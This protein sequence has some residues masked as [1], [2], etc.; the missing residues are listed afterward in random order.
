MQDAA[1]YGWAGQILDINLSNGQIVKKPLTPEFARKWIGGEGFGAKILWDEVGPEVEDGLDPRNVL[2]YAAGPLNSTLAPNSGRLE[3]VTKSPLTGIFGDTNSGGYFAPEM[4]QAGYDVI[5]IRGKAEKPVYL[6]IDDDKVQIRDAG[7]LWGRDV[8]ETTARLQY[9]LGDRDVQVSCIGP[10]GENLVRFAIL[11]NNLTRAPGWTGC[12]A[13]AGSKN[14]KA[15]TIRGTRGVRIAHPQEFEEACREL[16]RKVRDNRMFETRRKIG[17]MYLFRMMHA[18]GHSALNNYNITQSSRKYLEKI[19][20]D[21]WARDYVV[22]QTSCHACEIHCGHFAEVREGPYKGLAADGFEY[23]SFGAFLS[24]YGSDNLSFAMAATKY[25]NDNGMDAT[26]PGLILAWLTDCFKRGIITLDDT[27]GLTLDWGDEKVALEILRKI[28]HR[29]GFGD[30]LAEGL[31][32]ASRKIGRGSGYY[33]QV[34]KG[35]PSFEFNVRVMYGCA[36]ASATSTRGGDHLK[37]WPY[38]ELAHAGGAPSQ[39]RWGNPHAGDNTSHEGKSEMTAYGQRV[40]TLI[41]SLGT[42]KFLSRLGLEGLDEKDYTRLLSLATGVDFTVE[43]VMGAADRIYNL[44]Q[45]YNIRLG[46]GRKDDTVPE[47]YVSEPCDSG[48]YEGKIVIKRENFEKMLTEFYR[49]RGWNE[50]TAAPTRETLEKLGLKDVADELERRNFSGEG[51]KPPAVGA[52][53]RPPGKK[54]RG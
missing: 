47:L 34:T 4:K 12:G 53:R 3:I 15:V 50:E 25:C 5:I 46:I 36:L 21:R 35:R 20:G 7:H 14:L 32:R 1:G 41:D 29:E 42:C 18:A 23:G 26:E 11:M 28:N 9:E 27:D 22:R 13:V 10:A 39:K 52:E 49:H 30:I 54:T 37:G 24:A 2:I 44:E 38:Y 17:T 45:A 16:R 8:Q 6:W 48:P 43:E 19:S 40:F 51:K 33:A 31:G